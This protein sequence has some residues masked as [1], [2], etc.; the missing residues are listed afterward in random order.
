[1]RFQQLLRVCDDPTAPFSLND[2]GCG[3]GALVPY[4]KQRGLGATYRGFDLSAA[5]LKHAREA[6]ERPPEV[7]FAKHEVELKPADYT[8]ASGIFNVRLDVPDGQW[9]EYVLR[10]LDKLA[11][12]SSGAFAFNMLTTYS[13]PKKMRPDLYYGDPREL[14][15]HCIRRYSRQVALLHDY[16]LWEFTIIVRTG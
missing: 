4:L 1:M 7:T 12:L 10:T 8:V 11:E 15:N 16:E 2:Y 6:Y 9:R 13:E 5:M 3:Y 14:F